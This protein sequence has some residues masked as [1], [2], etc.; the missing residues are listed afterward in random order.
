MKIQYFLLTFILCAIGSMNVAKM[1]PE[2]ERLPLSKSFERNLKF[3]R[4]NLNAIL[5]QLSNEIN[6]YIHETFED[7]I[8]PQEKLKA[9]AKLNNYIDF[10]MGDLGGTIKQLIAAKNLLQHAAATDKTIKIIR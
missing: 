8:N 2:S 5:M 6:S 10:Y 9:I 4:D 1:I 3:S 7:P